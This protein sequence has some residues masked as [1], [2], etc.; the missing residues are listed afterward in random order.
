MV[1][2]YFSTLKEPCSKVRGI[3]SCFLK[4]VS[5]FDLLTCEPLV[6]KASP[7]RDVATFGPLIVQ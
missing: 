5:I 6:D 2:N 1:I 3:G 4:D 7:L